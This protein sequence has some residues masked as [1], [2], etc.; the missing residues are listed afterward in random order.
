MS[1]LSLIPSSSE[2]L[3]RPAKDA[4]K[5]Y[6]GYDQ[7]RPL[8]AEIIET[9]LTKND[10]LVLMPTGGGKSICFQI[11]AIITEGVCVVVSPLIA[12]MKDQVEGLVANGVKAAFLNSSIG[13]AKQFEIEHAAISGQLDLL[14]VSPEKLLSQSF[15]ETL[16]RIKLTMFAIDEAHC[17]SSWGHD[18]RPEYTQMAFLK[19]KYPNV[20]IIALTATADKATRSD[21]LK[22]LGLGHAR[23]FLASFDRPNLSL[24]VL[25]GQN[26][27]K[28]ILKFVKDRAGQ[29]GIVYALSRKSCEQIAGKL[30]AQGINADF[31]HAG[32]ST[33]Q[34]NVT[35]ENFIN[36][37]TE[38]ICATVAFGMGIDKSNIRWVIHYNLPK[39]IESYYQEI[40]RAGR[41]GVA[42]ETMLFYSFQDV[43]IYREMFEESPNKELKLEKLDR[44]M[45]YADSLNCRRK[46][47]L[48]YF[49][50]TLK[51]DCGNCDVCENPPAVFDGTVI[52]QKILSCVIRLEEKVGI[53]MVI[54]VLR[55]SG[56]KE[57]Y[58][59]LYHQ[60]KTYGAGRDISYFDWRE[61]V[62][63]IINLGLLEV[64]YHE[65]S[66]LKLN[67]ASWEVLKGQRSVE[68]ANLVSVKEKI[69]ERQ[70]QAKKKVE[71]SGNPLF[72]KLRA[73]RKSLAE[74]K[75][76]PPY[77]VFT[78][79]T[80]QEM[81]RL[82]PTSLSDLR[83][84]SGVGEFKLETYGADF[85]SEINQY[86]AR[87]KK[88]K[89]ATGGTKMVTFEMH[90]K[91]MSVEEISKE[92]NLKEQTIL[93]HLIDLGAEGKKI[94]WGDFVTPEEI[95]VI[96]RAHAVVSEP[97]L[98]P[99]FNH[100][101]GQLS[102]EKIKIVLGMANTEKA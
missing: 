84:V 40:G 98:K 50:E 97:G 77:L 69:E 93:N 80:L 9:V 28:H 49:G 47:L 39:N 100:L 90:E 4:L 60:I 35:Q 73:L 64:A 56:K 7:F 62:G 95:R 71:S 67:P 58:Q 88:G 89:Q 72:E 82:L 29:A 44:M 34:R 96:N 46:I 16:G 63:Q 61:Y 33:E 11:P 83:E 27:F 86:I 26:R 25:P 41:D 42:S 70:K 76:L 94:D 48:S 85:L 91:G 51:E 57:I 54:D 2:E 14:Y 65:K 52:A 3:M 17:I 53:G 13:G 21:I 38:I 32:M 55:G 87:T 79:A 22:Q 8:Q 81:T 23:T 101:E 99:I 102:Y 37:H 45:H 19:Q 92:R 5:L 12:L 15:I 31:Y 78:D 10:C 1:Q 18:F 66:T 74:E 30:Q 59:K 43:R 68:L 20:P 6:F 24:T 75:G 36:D